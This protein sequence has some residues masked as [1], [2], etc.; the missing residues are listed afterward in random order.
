M[1]IGKVNGSFMSFVYILQSKKTSRYYIG[2]TNNVSRR[3]MEHNAGQ[4]R[5]L[6]NQRPLTVVFQKQYG[7]ILEA[8]KIERRL[9]KCKSR[10]ILERIISDKE[11]K[12]GP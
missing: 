11:I 2:S 12:L 10:V 9:K 6:R 5:S 8:R 1:D 7:T 4:T 3:L